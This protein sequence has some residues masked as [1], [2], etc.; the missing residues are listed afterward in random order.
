VRAYS[1]LKLGFGYVLMRPHLPAL[2]FLQFRMRPTCCSAKK[3]YALMISLLGPLLAS[4]ASTMTDGFRN[5]CVCVL[6]AWA[7]ASHVTCLQAPGYPVSKIRSLP[8]Y[9]AHTTGTLKPVENLRRLEQDYPELSIKFWDKAEMEME[10]KDIDNRLQRAGVVGAWDAYQALNAKACQC[11]LWKYMILWKRGG[12]AFD[13][14]VM[15]RG[16]LDDWLTLAEDEELAVCHDPIGASTFY[17]NGSKYLSYHNS[18]LS[19]KPKSPLLLAA[20]NAIIETVSQRSYTLLDAPDAT[21]ENTYQKYLA[22]SATVLLGKIVHGSPRLRVDCRLSRRI[23]LSRGYELFIRQ[24]YNSADGGHYMPRDVAIFDAEVHT[25][26]YDSDGGNWY[27]ELWETG[28]I[29]T[30]ETGN[31]HFPVLWPLRRH[32]LARAAWEA[33]WK[34]VLDSLR[35]TRDHVFCQSAA[36]STGQRGRP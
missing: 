33:G 20:I 29:Y 19:A 10:I 8:A 15:L 11:D 7:E 1:W 26:T 31:A 14:K 4:L 12:I 5:V 9:I 23:H 27:P 6:C 16:S 13:P 34:T 18:V 2:H 3:R 36:N 21:F 25:A 32:I 30:S 24:W 28:R 22:I 35:H 17:V